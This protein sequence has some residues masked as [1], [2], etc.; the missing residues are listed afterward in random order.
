MP[1]TALIKFPSNKSWCPEET[2]KQGK[3]APLSILTCLPFF[4][5]IAVDLVEV[6]T[7]T[8]CLLLFQFQ[9]L[10]YFMVNTFISL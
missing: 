5:Q 1:L 9:N 7:G 10:G 6:N 3:H 4:S 8:P 2:V